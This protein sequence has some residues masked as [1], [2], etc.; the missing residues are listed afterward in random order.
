MKK[1]QT[2]SGCGL[3]SPLLLELLLNVLWNVDLLQV[4]HFRVLISNDDFNNTTAGVLHVFLWL[5]LVV[6]TEYQTDKQT[7]IAP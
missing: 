7:T 1:A 2:Y 4:I 3:G 5:P 6:L